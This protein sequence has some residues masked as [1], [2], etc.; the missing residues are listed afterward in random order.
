MDDQSAAE[1]LEELADAVEQ[2]GD[3]NPP[4]DQ[5]NTQGEPQNGQSSEGNAGSSG[6][7]NADS[8]G[9]RE[10]DRPSERLGVEGVPLELEEDGEGNIPNEEDTGED[11]PTGSGPNSV[12][13]RSGSAN[14]D[15]NTENIGEDPQRIP[16]DL[17]DVVRE[18]F[19]PSP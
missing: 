11:N 17:R 16:A 14:N 13:E 19:S 7:G 6:A 2:L 9:Q 4:Q 1:G 10:L 5:S 18:Y 12:F 8:T 15:I 3:D